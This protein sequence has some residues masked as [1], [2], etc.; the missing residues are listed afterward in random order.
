IAQGL[1]DCL[2]TSCAEKQLDT[3]VLSGGVFQNELLL[4]DVKTIVDSTGLQI[5]TNHAVPP[6]DGGISLGQAA[7]AAFGRFDEA[8]QDDSKDR[9]S[10]H[11]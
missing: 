2:R 1:C 7:L 3:I 9:S 5:W 8:S 11:A 4:W 6:N 10:S